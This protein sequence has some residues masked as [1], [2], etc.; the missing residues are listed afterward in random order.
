MMFDPRE[1]VRKARHKL[2]LSDT[3]AASQI[4][5]SISEYGDIEQHADELASTVA[6]KDVRR[7]SEVLQLELFDLIGLS[8]HERLAG[9]P[10]AKRNELIGLRMGELNLS[11]KQLADQLGFEESAIHAML[12]DP[13]F[14]EQW[15]IDLIE[16]L[17][18]EIKVPISILLG[19]SGTDPNNP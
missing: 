12:L 15:P 2:G 11:P 17:A 16:S 3:E 1:T 14:L 10:G 13:Q 9:S 8:S 7:L 18:D 19:H 6:L 4:G 5:I